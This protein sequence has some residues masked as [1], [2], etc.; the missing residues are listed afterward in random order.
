MKR[1]FMF[2]KVCAYLVGVIICA[3][4][5]LISASEPSKNQLA[6]CAGC[7]GPQGISSLPNYPNLANQK[8]DYLIK[9]L[10]DFKK[11]IRTDPTMDAMVATLSDS[12][13]ENLATY[14][15]NL[16]CQTAKKD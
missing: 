15:S 5:G 8:K 4:S 1:I 12:D 6:I 11:K 13:I 16:S 7:H 14:Y 3:S 10:Q 2:N 9:S